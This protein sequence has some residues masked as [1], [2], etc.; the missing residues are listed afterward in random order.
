MQVDEL[1]AV[2]GDDVPP[3]LEWRIIAV[4]PRVVDQRFPQHTDLGLGVKGVQLAAP[5][6]DALRIGDQ[7]GAGAL[8]IGDIV[9]VTA[10]ELPH[11]RPAIVGRPVGDIR[12][13]A[14]RAF[15]VFR[16]VV[17][18]DRT[19]GKAALEQRHQTRFDGD[20]DV[21]FGADLFDQIAQR[22]GE[23]DL[24]AQPLF[25]RHEDAL[26]LE[27]FVGRPLRPV[28]QVLHLGGRAVLVTRLIPFPRRYQVAV[29]HIGKGDAE[30][31]GMDVDGVGEHRQGGHQVLTRALDVALIEQNV[32]EI[33]VGVDV[34]RIV[35]QRLGIEDG[36]IGQVAARIDDGAQRIPQL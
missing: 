2:D 29:G 33:V 31:A 32:A 20:G 21:A 5:I 30:L 8:E 17:L 18:D 23:H 34:V 22:A 4:A 16:C 13:E 6:G 24:V 12:E 25:G 1:H 3:L 11:D 7:K 28:D 35:A 15:L 10:E 14:H 26:A 19:T 27:R 36:G 9:A